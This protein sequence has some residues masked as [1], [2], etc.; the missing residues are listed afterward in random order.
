MDEKKGV[1][2]VKKTLIAVPCFDMVHADFMESVVNLEK[3]ENT[4]FT[5]VKNTMIYSAR[6]I[7]A[8]NA[9]EYGFERVLWLDSDMRFPKDMVKRLSDDM[10]ETGAGLVTGLYFTRKPPIKPNIFSELWLEQKEDELDAGATMIYEYPEGII[11]IVAC[12][13][14]CCLTSVDLIKK[15]GDKF[16]SPFTP[17][18]GMGEDLSFCFRVKQLG[19]KQVCDTRIK[20]DHIGQA[21]YN[22]DFYK[23]QPAVKCGVDADGIPRCG[24]CGEEVTYGSNYCLKC[25]RRLSW[26]A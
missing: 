20:C 6:N 13:F 22:E 7:V 3:H 25:G 21:V 16:G 4:F 14:G 15:V 17:I 9:I 23:R 26:D 24:Y 5:T 10:D 1:M 19:E 2:R 8:A 18:D 11:D 12:G